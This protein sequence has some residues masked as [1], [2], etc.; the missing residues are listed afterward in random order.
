MVDKKLGLVIAVGVAAFVA[1]GAAT[2]LVTGRQAASTAP[3]AVES[4][5][6]EGGIVV[7]RVDGK[8]IYLADVETAFMHLPEQAQQLGMD[9][10][11]APLLQRVIDT[12]LLTDEAMA[13][14]PADDA[15]VATQLGDLRKQITVQ[16]YFERELAARMTEDRIKAAYDAHVAANPPQ[17]EVHARHIL[18]ADEA[19]AKEVLALIQGGKDFTEA[20]TEFSTGPSGPTGGDL[21]FFTKDRMVAPFA[22]AAFK[23]QPGEISAAPVQ[24]E[25]GW[26]IIKVEERRT[27]PVP[28][29]DD[30]REELKADLSSTI[31]GEMIDALHS[32]VKIEKFDKDGNPLP[33]EEA[34]AAGAVQPQQ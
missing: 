31:A 19:K 5:I 32:G 29:L 4:K 2:W 9:M 22:E 10:I 7:A 27:Q 11:Y 16:V 23:M 25:F 3:A 34:P 30:M 26:H 14:M 1:G 28:T 12:R 17:E 18:L 8:P 13:K 24:T 33:D 21:G 15:E 20:A 6:R